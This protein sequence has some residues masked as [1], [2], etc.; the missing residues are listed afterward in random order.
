[1]RLLSVAPFLVW[2][3]SCLIAGERRWEHV[4]LMLLA[5]LLAYGNAWSRRLFYGLFPIG[6]LGLVCARST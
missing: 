2:P 4:V 1:L 6:L 5:P 3:L